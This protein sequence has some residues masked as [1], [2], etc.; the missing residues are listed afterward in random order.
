MPRARVRDAYSTPY[1]TPNTLQGS[2][3]ARFLDTLGN[4][5]GTVRSFLGRTWELVMPSNGAGLPP[6]RLIHQTKF[7]NTLWNAITWVCGNINSDGVKDDINLPAW[8]IGGEMRYDDGTGG[9]VGNV[10]AEIYGLFVAQGQDG[11]TKQRRVWMFTQNQSSY[12]VNGTFASDAFTF[13]MRPDSTVATDGD[14]STVALSWFPNNFSLRP[15]NDADN[16]VE[17]RAR[18]GRVAKLFLGSGTNNSRVWFESQG[19]SGSDAQIL[20]IKA[21]YSGQSDQTIMRFYRQR[22]SDTD[23]TGSIAIGGIDENTATV[24]VQSPVDD[25]TTYRLKARASQTANL[26]EAQTSTGTNRF[27]V[28][29]GARVSGNFLAVASLSANGTTISSTAVLSAAYTLADTAD[30][31]NTAFRLPAASS[32]NVGMVLKGRNVNA[33]R[34]ILIFPN[35]GIQQINALSAGS[36]ISVAIGQGFEAVCET[37]SRWSVRLLS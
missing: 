29:S 24:V 20:Q 37:A 3:A 27:V 36:S 12:F 31:S 17:I 16:V 1:S 21:A 25:L 7:F 13:F 8:A 9:V 26:L 30:A 10:L 2:P 35:T 23:A 18:S 34:A 11:S 32:S 22:F 33:S 28:D 5:L 4:V 15:V 6:G 14:L 19:N